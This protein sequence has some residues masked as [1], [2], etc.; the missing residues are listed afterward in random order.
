MCQLVSC[1]FVPRHNRA[2]TTVGNTAHPSGTG[3]QGV[4]RCDRLLKCPPGRETHHCPFRSNWPT[5]VI[6]WPYEE[7]QPYYVPGGWRDRIFASSASDCRAIQ[8]SLLLLLLLFS[9]WD[10]GVSPRPGS[11]HWQNKSHPL[12]QQVFIEQL[13]CTRHCL[14]HWGNYGK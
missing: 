4:G 3:D 6:G 5:P 12:S 13:L 2:A 11:S 7:A 8:P 9:I 1:G 14:R 10:R